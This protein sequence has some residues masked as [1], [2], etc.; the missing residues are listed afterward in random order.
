MNLDGLKFTSEWLGRH[1]NVVADSSLDLPK[2][3]SAVVNDAYLEL[4]EWDLS[5]PFPEVK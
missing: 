2:K 4:L 5:K 1:T 3:I